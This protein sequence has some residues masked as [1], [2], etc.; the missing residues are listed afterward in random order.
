MINPTAFLSPQINIAVILAYNVEILTYRNYTESLPIVT[1]E[2]L[3]AAETV[4][5]AFSTCPNIDA[6]TRRSD[7][8]IPCIIHEAQSR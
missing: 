7:A 3:F 8:N 2:I 4:A 6:I 5:P 1:N